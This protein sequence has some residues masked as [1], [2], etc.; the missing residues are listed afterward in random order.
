M[1]KLISR[2]A[3][4]AQK[5]KNV[6]TEAGK[7]LIVGGLCTVLDFALLFS[8]EQYLNVHFL[9]ASVL[10]F[11]AGTVLNYYLCTYWI[12]KVRRVTDR[13]LEMGFYLVITAVGLAI[14]S[15]LIW[16]LTSQFGYHFMLSK[17][18][19]T[20]ATFWWNFGARKWF[21]HRSATSHR[22]AQHTQPTTLS[23][24]ETHHEKSLHHHGPP[25]P[26][27]IVPAD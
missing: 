20:A 3:A 17:L 2:T 11:T 25:V 15:A 21:L 22:P 5:R 23:T 12:F 27:A 24:Y 18:A 7:Y 9:T 26:G 16:M 14:N 19:A 4:L 13:R 8:L 10:S 1:K 6:L